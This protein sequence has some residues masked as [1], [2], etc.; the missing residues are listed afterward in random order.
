MKNVANLGEHMLS[1]PRVVEIIGPAGAGKTTLFKALGDY[2][3]HI[4]LSYYPDVHSAANVPFFVWYGLLL[5]PSLLRI[6]RRPSRWLSR[7]EFASLTIIKGWPFILKR[8]VKKTD[9]VIL[10]DQ[11]PVFMLAEMRK[12]GPEYLTRKT[13]EKFWQRLYCKWANTLD[14]IIWLDAKDDALMKRIQVR[15]K[16]HLVKHQSAPAISDF[17]AGYR[18]TYE[19]IVAALGSCLNGPRVLRFDT[20][21]LMPSQIIKQLLTEFCIS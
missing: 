3:E 1:I 21:M 4:R 17:L 9:Q 15:P 5:F 18:R 11:G 7:R 16:E 14:L 8:E 10:L 20:G 19:D 12:F 2:P 6:Y 13:T